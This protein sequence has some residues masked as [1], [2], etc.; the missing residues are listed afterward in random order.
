MTT[1]VGK[2]WYGGSEIACAQFSNFTNAI[3]YMTQHTAITYLMYVV[4]K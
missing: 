4:D 1:R 2:E 3:N